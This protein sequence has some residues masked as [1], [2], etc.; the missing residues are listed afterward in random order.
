ML[1]RGVSYGPQLLEGVTEPDGHERG[2]MFVS[3]QA[4]IERQ[5][6]F[7]QQQWLGDGNV[8]GLG[9]DRDPL[10]AGASV[11]GDGG[12]MVIQGSPPLF[13]SGLPRFVTMRGGGYFLLPGRAG[14]QALVTAE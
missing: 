10:G 14:L 8:F 9:N 7:V 11:N 2:L 1:R 13:L 5:F 12:R 6:E 3:Y 4:S